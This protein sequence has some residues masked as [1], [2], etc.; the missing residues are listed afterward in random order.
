MSSLG[1]LLPALLAAG[2]AAYAGGLPAKYLAVKDIKRGMKGYGLSVFQGTKPERFEVEVL[3]V[4]KN[5]FPKQDI[6][7]ARM[8][9]AGLEKTGIIAGMSGSPIYLRVGNEDK[10]AGAVAYGWMFPKEPVCGFTP[11]ENMHAVIESTASEKKSAAEPVG[12]GAQLDAPITLAGRTF[13]DVRLAAAPPTWERM[14]GGAASLCRL[15]TPLYVSGMTEPGFELAR[16]EF[17]PLG[18]MPVQ[19]GAASAEE[20]A[21]AKIEPGG[22]LALRLAEGDI[23][24][25]GIGTCTEVMGDTVLAFGHPM[26]GEG[27]VKVPMATAVVHYCYP[28]TMRSFKLASP[29]KTVGTVT[30]DMQAAVMGK[31]GAAPRMIPIEARLR[32][33]D[34]AGE[35][36]YSCRAFDHP[37][38]TSR[39]IGMF[40]F[41]ALVTRGD[42]PRENTL[43]FRATVQLAQ[44]PPLVIENVYSDIGTYRALF[45]ALNDIISP[46]AVLGSNEFGKVDVEKVTADFQVTTEA[47]VARVEA[48]RLERNDY[49]PGDV[50]RALATIR[51]PKKEPI[52]QR[53]ELKLPDDFPPGNST[54]MICDP[55]M[56]QRLDRA[57]APHRY[58]P[59]NLDQLVEVLREQAPQR[60]LCIR[61]QLP[62]RG[63][64]LRG[65]ELPSLPSSMLAIVASMKTTGVSLT[66]KSISAYVETPFVV[67]GSHA[68]PVLIRPR[69][70]P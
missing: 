41:N 34:M 53:L 49:M 23:E 60:R 50:I 12:G 1:T 57:D 15:Q 19:G 66:A 61:L 7:L 30:A 45:E 9:G 10:L 42:F 16:K 63:V 47:T 32:R 3:G 36:T 20:A 67:S 68:L 21:G 58:Q 13:T 69:Q 48:V 55:A 5:A 18:F 64:A 6:V 51:P 59:T 70:A 65:V 62:E 40:L 54:V 27:R 31:L 37:R 46:V 4:L 39:I 8:S 44:R 38:M 43:T 29:G 26:F 24:L 28:S 2:V 56:N 17:E 25:S 52:I 14:S 33:A 11:F 35:E 22:A